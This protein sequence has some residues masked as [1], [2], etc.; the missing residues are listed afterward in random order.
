MSALTVLGIGNGPEE[1]HDKAAPIV[2]EEHDLCWL[3]IYIED[4]TEDV[5][6]EEFSENCEKTCGMTIIIG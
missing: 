5:L 2:I 3:W 1:H 6:T 4:V